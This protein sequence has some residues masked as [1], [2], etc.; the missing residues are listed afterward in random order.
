MPS[1]TLYK[2]AGEYQRLM[3]LAT[4][5]EADH[6]V[7]LSQEFIETLEQLEGV[8]TGKIEG[9][10]RAVKSMLALKDAIDEETEALRMRAKRLDKAVDE[11]KHYMQFNLEQMEIRKMQAGIFKVSICQNSQP[12]VIVLDLD[13]VPSKF[14]K[15]QER[16]ISKS[17]IADAVKAGEVVPG[18]DVVRGSHVRIS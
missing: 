9:C 14:D 16:E 1:I 5:D 18:V 10:C 7:G 13:A 12:S 8:I 6:S 17:R 2:L 15:I 3:D 4:D 11:L